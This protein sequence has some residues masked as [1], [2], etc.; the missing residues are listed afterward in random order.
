MSEC[1][2]KPTQ[3]FAIIKESRDILK[4]KLSEFNHQLRLN[5]NILRMLSLKVDKRLVEAL[6]AHARG[7]AELRPRPVVEA[8]AAAVADLDE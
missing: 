3:Q 2:V 1:T 8:V 4:S 6:V 7:G 5:E